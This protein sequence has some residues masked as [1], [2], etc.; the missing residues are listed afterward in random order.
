MKIFLLLLLLSSCSVSPKT[1]TNA[2]ALEEP[3]PPVTLPETV[4]PSPPSSSNENKPVVEKFSDYFVIPPVTPINR[5]TNWASVSFMSNF[6][7]G[8]IVHKTAKENPGF[9]G[10]WEKYWREYTIGEP[11]RNPNGFGNTG[12]TSNGTT[13]RISSRWFGGASNRAIYKAIFDII[14]V[15]R[16]KKRPY[17]LLQFKTYEGSRPNNHPNVSCFFV[18]GVTGA[19][20]KNNLFRENEYYYLMEYKA[21]FNTTPGY[22]DDNDY[23]LVLMQAYDRDTHDLDLGKPFIINHFIVVYNSNPRSPEI[24]RSTNWNKAYLG[25]GWD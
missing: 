12:I 7:T 10:H 5:D 14:H 9:N 24:Y 15:E 6:T 19:M 4:N 17:V 25:G 20:E 2:P 23:K 11:E 22:E 18:N 13:L 3:S 21:P 1:G 8:F 16:S